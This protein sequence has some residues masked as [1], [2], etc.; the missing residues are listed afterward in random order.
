MDGQKLNFICRDDGICTDKISARP[1]TSN[2]F[3]SRRLFQALQADVMYQMVRPD[4]RLA[5]ERQNYLPHAR[6]T[7]HARKPCLPHLFLALPEPFTTWLNGTASPGSDQTSNRQ[8]QNHTAS[9][10]GLSGVIRA[11]D[12]QISQPTSFI[13]SGS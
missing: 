4:R 5:S 9:R 11:A 3:F 6:N 10:P 2:R 1:D 7:V 12:R 13:W 8:S